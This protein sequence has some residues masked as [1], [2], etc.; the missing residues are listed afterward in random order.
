[1]RFYID[2]NIY[3]DYFREN[4]KEGLTPLTELLKLLKTKKIS[5][6]LPQQTKQEYFRNKYKIIETTRNVLVKQA[7]P[8]LVLPSGLNKEMKEVREVKESLK[9]FKK[10][11][12]KLIE[13]YD[14]LVEKEKTDA[15][16]LIKEIFDL[17]IVPEENKDVVDRAHLRYMKGNPPRKSDYSYGDSII[18]ETLLGKAQED[19]LCI[20]T[21]DGDF[22]DKRQ[23]SSVVNH[24]LFVEWRIKTKKKKNLTLYK[25]LAEAINSVS[26]KK[27]IKK[28]IIDK[29]KKVIRSEESAEEIMQIYRPSN[30]SGQDVFIPQSVT[31]STTNTPMSTTLFSG[32]FAFSQEDKNLCPFCGEKRTN[33]S[34]TLAS[35][36]SRCGKIF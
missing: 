34:L 11:Q 25:S 10:A 15:D 33:I 22:T 32:T 30:F 20:I 23:G 21:R 3:L 6:I 27:I 31:L 7:T 26:K 19:D 2:A 36:C 5:L 24:F 16:L 12:T 13:Q 17:A 29:E 9:N 1:M 4:S 14:R 18:W 35:V 8:P 28:K